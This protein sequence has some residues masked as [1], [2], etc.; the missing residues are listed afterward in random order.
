MSTE[1]RIKRTI[2]GREVELK[3]GKVYSAK[4]PIRDRGDVYSV[5]ITGDVRDH[6]SVLRDMIMLH[7]FTYSAALAFC[8]EF[9]N[10]DFTFTGRYWE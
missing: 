5:M 4:W 7:D 1:R 6:G 9:N 10:Q 3:H 8:A 2:A